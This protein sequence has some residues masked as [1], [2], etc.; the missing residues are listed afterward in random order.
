[1]QDARSKNI[2]HVLIL[3]GDQLYR[4]DYMSFIKACNVGF[5]ISFNHFMKC[6]ME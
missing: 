1:M 3:C 2:E 4:M 6:M 5:I